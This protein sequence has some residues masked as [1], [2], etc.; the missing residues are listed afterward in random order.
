MSSVQIFSEIGRL[1]KVML[2]R[3]G[4]EIE[5]IIPE[6]LENLLFDD[7]PYLKAARAEHDVFAEL[8]RQN[9]VEVYYLTSMLREI[10]ADG[11]VRQ[12]FVEEFLLESNIFSATLRRALVEYLSWLPVPDM[13]DKMMSGIRK[14]EV[15]YISSSLSDVLKNDYEFYLDPMPNLYFTR[16]PSACIGNGISINTMK[17]HTRRRETLF[18]KYLHRYHP[19]F[20]NPET[21][22]LY[23]RILQAPIEGGD[24]L[25]LS[26]ESIAIGCSERT[27]ADAIE[28]LASE[29]FAR[30]EDFQSVLVFQI[31]KKRAYMHLDTVFTMVDGDKFAIHPGIEHDLNIYEVTRGRDTLKFKYCDE[32]LEKILK[33]TLKIDAVS[34]IRCGGNDKIISD[35][36]QWNDGSN[37]LAIAPGV[38]VTYERNYV[39]N[40]LLDKNGVKVLTIPSSELSRGRGGPRCMSM[41]INR[42][43]V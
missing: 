39:S 32:G 2:H 36:E 30:R 17:T 4:P 24:E 28:Y 6:Y 16:D 40:E 33:K 15:K 1:K 26:P 38:V 31:Q 8:L 43:L 29:I 11:E 19:V 5:N 7:I 34:L 13:I 25:V 14:K 42:D 20:N 22:L 37:T 9:G 41:P 21:P 10:L 27:S 23:D 3:P 12:S 35:R 18:I